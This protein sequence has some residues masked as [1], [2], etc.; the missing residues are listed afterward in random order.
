MGPSL[1]ELL[2]KKQHTMMVEGGCAFPAGH[3]HQ[4]I[5]GRRS[6]LLDKQ[7]VVAQL[8]SPEFL[9]ER[10]R[11]K[12]QMM[13]RKR[14]QLFKDLVRQGFA[15]TFQMLKEKVSGAN[16]TPIYDKNGMLMIS[17]SGL[18]SERTE[19]KKNRSKT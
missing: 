15:S 19:W 3:H 10:R 8:T 14:N 16:M 7:A 4:L 12:E 11:L 18:K 17:F 6:G 1:A 9:M 2:K 13:M 5:Q